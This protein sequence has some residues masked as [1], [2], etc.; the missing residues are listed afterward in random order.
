MNDVHVNQPRRAALAPTLTSLPGAVWTAAVLTGLMRLPGLLWPIRPDEAGF[1]LVARA[2]DPQPDS[3][4]GDYWVD[5]P[6]LVIAVVKA[7]DAV[8]GPYFLRVVTALAC[9]WL[10]VAAG[11]TARLIAGDRAATWSAVATAALTSSA[12]IDPVVAKGEIL[13]IPLVVTSFGLALLAL[14]RESPALAA[15]AGLVA[16]C[17]LGLKQNMVGGLVFG[18]V[19][20]LA[21]WL[22]GQ[23]SRTTFRQ[24]ARAAA[25]GAAMPVLA[26]VVWAVWSGVRLDAVWYAVF[27][28]RGDAFAVIASGPAGAPHARAWEMV[29]IVL[30]SG[31]AWVLAGFVVRLGAAWRVDRTVTAATLAVILVDAAGLVLGGSYWRPYLFL[32]VPGA[33]LCVALFAGRDSREGQ[34]MRTGVSVAVFSCAASWV[35]LVLATTGGS[36]VPSEY[37]TGEAVG[38]AARPTDT[39]LVYGGR[40]DIQYASGLTSPYPYLWSLPMRTRDLEL[41]ELRTVLAGKDAPTWIVEWVDFHAWE[42]PGADAVERI[43]R[44]RYVVHGKGCD[45]RPIYLR[46]GV[47][48]APLVLDCDQPWNWRAG[49]LPRYAG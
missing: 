3:M 41:A 46:R 4:F 19:L 38:A 13:G 40:A 21:A 25:A 24:L 2:W 32:L 35:V 12:L 26:T 14:R 31:L 42:T 15:A 49:L 30:V 43:V 36:V 22:S 9:V 10:V 1:T 44:A 28:F 5:R 16:T 11:Q 7:A 47:N 29:G 20:L 39:M 23:I 45:D 37:Y 27:G 6:P 18:G 8:G 33:A 34:T 48:R 17:A